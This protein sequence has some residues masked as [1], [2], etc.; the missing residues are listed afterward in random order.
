[1]MRENPLEKF[2]TVQVKDVHEI[3]AVITL[4]F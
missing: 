1:M 2:S 3:M 4:Y